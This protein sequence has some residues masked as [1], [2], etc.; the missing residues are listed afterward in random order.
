MPVGAGSPK[1]VA[2]SPNINKPA[3]PQRQNLNL[4]FASINPRKK[5]GRVYFAC[6]RSANIVGEPAPTARY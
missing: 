6:L 1:T 3:P 5:R 2:C 4:L